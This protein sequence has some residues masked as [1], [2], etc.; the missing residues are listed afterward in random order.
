M[1]DNM[2]VID[3]GI[4]QMADPQPNDFFFIELRVTI[5]RSEQRWTLAIN[6]LAFHYNG[7]L[8]IHYVPDEP[9]IV[10]QPIDFHAHLPEVER[11]VGYTPSNP[12]GRV[13]THSYRR[14]L[15]AL[16]ERGRVSG[17]EGRDATREDDEPSTTPH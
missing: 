10:T 1:G 11:I 9:I 16:R 3:V 2:G 6:L 12:Q 8:I 7:L 17:R 14:L 4:E 5:P 15:R 13:T